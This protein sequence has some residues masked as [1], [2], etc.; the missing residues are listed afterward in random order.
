MAGDGGPLQLIK[1]ER[2]QSL[3]WQQAERQL[4]RDELVGRRAFVEI[5]PVEFRASS[6]ALV[7]RNEV[8]YD[9]Y[10][11]PTR[12]GNVGGKPGSKRSSRALEITSPISPKP[13][14]PNN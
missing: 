6:G 14:S 12:E 4:T 1:D 10:A 3:T 11:A 13:P 5:R 9:G 2:V 8:P 7:R